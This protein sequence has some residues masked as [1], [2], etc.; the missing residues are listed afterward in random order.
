ME[1]ILHH[2]IGN[3]SHYLWAFIHP[4]WLFGISSIINDIPPL[5]LEFSLA[6][7]IFLYC[8]CYDSVGV[9]FVTGP[10]GGRKKSCGWVG[11]MGCRFVPIQYIFGNK[12]SATDGTKLDLQPWY[13]VEHNRWCFF[14]KP[15]DHGIFSFT[16]FGGE[17]LLIWFILFSKGGPATIQIKVW[18]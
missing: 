17:R 3:L 11:P 10:G 4:R 7:K 12:Q 2:L 13:L 8:K 6:T 14:F 15:L 9:R 1:E 5:F 18:C 16:P